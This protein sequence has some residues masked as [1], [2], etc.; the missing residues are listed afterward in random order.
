MMDIGDFFSLLC[1]P[2][3]RGDLDRRHQGEELHCAACD[4]AF[5][6]VDGIPVL[7][8]CNVKEQMSDLFGRYWDSED[9]AQL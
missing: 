7:L 6:I 4:F 8:P 5:P 3:C 2:A 9:N 1:C